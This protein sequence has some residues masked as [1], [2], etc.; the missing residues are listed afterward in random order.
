MLA[1]AVSPDTSLVAT[2]GEDGNAFFF[3]LAP[4]AE[5]G[6]LS[7]VA[8]VRLGLSPGGGGGGARVTCASWDASGRVLLVG[9]SQ[10]AILQV[11]GGFGGP[12]G[13]C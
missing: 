13:G 11:R 7:P 6:A 9:T 2:C 8:F 3:R 10:G 12:G 1:V 5:G 4:A